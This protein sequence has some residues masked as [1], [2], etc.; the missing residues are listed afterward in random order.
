MGRKAQLTLT[1]VCTAK[2]DEAFASG[3]EEKLITALYPLAQH[4][5]KRDTLATQFLMEHISKRLHLY[6][7]LKEA[8]FSTW[9]FRVLKFRFIDWIRKQQ[10]E[11]GRMAVIVHGKDTDD[12]RA[13]EQL[14]RLCE[15]GI[16]AP[17]KFG[18]RELQRLRASKALQMRREGAS[19]A[20]IAA[21]LSMGKRAV[22]PS[23][24]PAMLSRWNR[25]R[26]YF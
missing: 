26:S 23:S 8:R 25:E 13:E 18:K 21:L 4:I 10:A 9:A 20:E 3:D 2:V 22:K 11:R 15:S 19:N 7:G 24:V 12:V 6:Q 1:K 14:E 17:E 16:P 5:T